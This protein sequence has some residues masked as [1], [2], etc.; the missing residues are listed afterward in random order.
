M[1]SFSEIA[2]RL[3]N[4]KTMKVE[5][6][7]RK[8]PPY[9]ILSHWWS[10]NETTFERFVDDNERHGAG[11]QKI[12]SFC[13]FLTERVL[14]EERLEWCWVDTCCIDRRS[15]SELSEAVNSMAAWYAGSQLCV[16]YL[17]DVPS[18]K[19]IAEA[20]VMDYVKESEWFSR[21]WT[22][23]ELLFSAEL[24]FCDSEWDEIHGLDK[25]S[26]EGSAQISTITGIPDHCIQK[27][28][29]IYHHCVADKMSWAALRETTRVEDEAYCLLGL[30]NI[31]MPLLY[32]EGSKAFF[33]LQREIIDRYED[34]SI[35][36]WLDAHPACNEHRDKIMPLLAPH[37]S[38]F[39][40]ISRVS[41]HRTLIEHRRPYRMTNRGLEI[42]TSAIEFSGLQGYDR[43]ISAS[44]EELL[45]IQ[46]NCS[47]KFS[48]EASGR[49]DNEPKLQSWLICLRRLVAHQQASVYVNAL[50]W[51]TGDTL[52]QELTRLKEASS[53]VTVR[54]R[55]P[56]KY[57][58]A[59]SNEQIWASRSA[60]I[61]EDNGQAT[62]AVSS[63]DTLMEHFERLG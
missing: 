61:V 8:R 28:D 29:I 53:G 37:P 60:S 38:W 32:G 7:D 17:S 21:G 51:T 6:F 25:N 5:S 16:A 36:A 49:A 59:A 47:A 22:L 57:Y 14:P 41:T 34:E 58:V 55:S 44:G 12:E 33:R 56:E 26:V 35:F 19:T 45:V 46:M 39:V 3:I 10:D 27:P 18:Q 50:C 23:Q 24:V 2:M 42:E 54:R 30:F 52:W 62:R 15:S 11:F 13:K 31:N 40:Y 43:A 63:L 48:C 20:A 1:P 4:I 9:A